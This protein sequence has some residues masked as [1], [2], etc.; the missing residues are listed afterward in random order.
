[1]PYSAVGMHSAEHSPIGRPSSPT[2]AP[3][4]VGF[5]TPPDVSNSFIAPSRLWRSAR[6]TATRSGSHR[7]LASRYAALPGPGTTKGPTAAESCGWGPSGGGSGGLGNGGLADSGPP[8]DQR[9]GA[10]P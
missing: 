6:Q 7:S 3:S 8:P 5:L 1:C 10:A 9:C 2:S 4:M